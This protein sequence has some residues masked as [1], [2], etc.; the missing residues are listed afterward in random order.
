[1]CFSTVTEGTLIDDRKFIYQLKPI[2][3]GLGAQGLLAV[4]SAGDPAVLGQYYN[5]C[6]C[7]GHTDAGRSQAWMNSA[8]VY[9]T[10]HTVEGPCSLL[11]QDQCLLL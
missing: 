5:P 6:L 4:P 1:M 3:A 9:F 8:P 10:L 2:K 7:S 11:G